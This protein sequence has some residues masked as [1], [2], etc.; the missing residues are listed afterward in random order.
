M[1]FRLYIYTLFF[2]TIIFSQV[3]QNGDFVKNLY[4]NICENDSIKWSTTRKELRN[5]L[6]IS[7][8]ATWWI[9]C[10][11]ESQE[12]EKI[13]KEFKN[14]GVEVIGAGMDWNNPYSC[15]EWIEK[16]NLTY[17]ILDDSKGEKIYNYFGNGVVPYN[18]VID[19]NMRLIYSSSGFNKDE[20]VDA[21]K[22]GLK[23]SIKQKLPLKKN[24]LS[25][26]S[27]TVYKKLREN[28]GFD[29]KYVFLLKGWTLEY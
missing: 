1:V 3:Y 29:W 21:I 13:H 25:L 2:I 27:K 15:E 7:S 8:F 6:F 11:T 20:I 10:Q 9:P 14:R 23:T 5:V 12:I 26:P 17:P 4:G 18:V 28:K 16:F 24:K 19:K 22:T